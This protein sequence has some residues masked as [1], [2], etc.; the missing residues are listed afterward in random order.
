MM[1]WRCTAISIDVSD[2][3]LPALIR[4][5]M[6]IIYLPRMDIP[7]HRIEIAMS[8]L[9][10]CTA[11]VEVVRTLYNMNNAAPTSIEKVY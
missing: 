8:E 5:C 1:A 10:S 9:H 3:S 4:T 7:L 11:R 6:G 2:A